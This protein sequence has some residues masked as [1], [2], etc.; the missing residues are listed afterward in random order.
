MRQQRW[1]S[2]TALVSTLALITFIAKTY[3]RY[4]I[5]EVEDNLVELVIGVLIAYGVYNN[6]CDKNSY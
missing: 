3:F 4:D 1:K 6:P 5:P 2:K